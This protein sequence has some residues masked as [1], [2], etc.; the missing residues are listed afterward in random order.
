[1]LCAESFFIR[2]CATPTFL[3]GVERPKIFEQE[4]DD[5]REWDKLYHAAQVLI[6]TSEKE[7]D[8]SIR[9][10]IVLDALKRKT[11]YA[12]RDV[13]ALPLACHR[14]HNGPYVRW[15]AAE[16]VCFLVLIV[17]WK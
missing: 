9:Q 13:K 16:N 15:H 17:S 5:D 10:K 4:A 6:G 2:T 3:K 12:D 1:V 8:S 14:I 11:E 7:F